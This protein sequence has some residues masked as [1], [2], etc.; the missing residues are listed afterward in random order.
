MNKCNKCSKI[1]ENKTTFSKIRDENNMKLVH[2]VYNR[3]NKPVINREKSSEKNMFM[4]SPP[5]EWKCLICNNFNSAERDY[6]TRCKK[7]K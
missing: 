5:H 7:N 1:L 6:C 2:F 4:N 3:I